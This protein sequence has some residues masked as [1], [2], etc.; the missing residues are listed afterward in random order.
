MPRSGDREI[1]LKWL[2]YLFSDYYILKI[3]NYIYYISKIYSKS[4]KINILIIILVIIFTLILS[5]YFLNFY[6]H[7]LEQFSSVY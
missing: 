1:E 7:N 3:K 6:I 5:I 2:S 4:L